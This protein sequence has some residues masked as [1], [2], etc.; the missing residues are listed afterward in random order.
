MAG[1]TLRA[2]GAAAETGGGCVPR[3]CRCGGS[4]WAAMRAGDPGRPTAECEATAMDSAAGKD[5][6][7]RAQAL[8]TGAHVL[9]PPGR[10]AEARAV[11]AAIDAT[12]AA[13]QVTRDVGGTANTEQVTDA[14]IEALAKAL[15]PA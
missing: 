6:L 11:G 4:G 14:I 9:A 3:P 2:R 5:P 8:I 15:V 12:P 10:P 13:G 1:L 7:H